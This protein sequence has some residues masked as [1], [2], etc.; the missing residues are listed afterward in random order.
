MNHVL[1]ML[2]PSQTLSSLLY[3]SSAFIIY[4]LSYFYISDRFRETACSIKMRIVLLP[5]GNGKSIVALVAY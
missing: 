2:L 4:F 3:A 1:L 5:S